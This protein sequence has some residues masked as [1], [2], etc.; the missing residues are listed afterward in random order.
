MT[1]KD[2]SY[3]PSRGAIYKVDGD[4]K[5]KY[6]LEPELFKKT[7]SSSISKNGQI[8]FTGYSLVEKEIVAKNACLNDQRVMYTFGK[9]FGDIIVTGEMLLGIPEGKSKIENELQEYYEAQRVHTK[10]EEPLTLTG[11]SGFTKEFYLVGL[12]I[13]QYNVALEI[14]GFRLT[15]VLAE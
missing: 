9:G 8:L 6:K 15:G 7:G 13:M 1:G 5:H 3:F 11:P 14:L 4:G 10:K 2:K 12:S